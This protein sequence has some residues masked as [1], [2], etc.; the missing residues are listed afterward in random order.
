ML[1]ANITVIVD[2]SFYTLRTVSPPVVATNLQVSSFKL[3][4]QVDTKVNNR[5]KCH[6]FN[7]LSRAINKGKRF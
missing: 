3:R 1:P 5:G 7:E 6:F 2:L 4:G